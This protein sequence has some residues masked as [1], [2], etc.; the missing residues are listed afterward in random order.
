MKIV[1]TG[2][3]TGGHFYPIIA[4]TE[5]IREICKQKKFIEPTLYFLAPDPYNEKILFDNKII[6]KRV[7]A[8]KLR[9]Y[10]SI[11]NFFDFFVT[12]F[13]LIKA[14]WTMFWIYPDVVFSKGGH[15]SVPIVW[16]ANVLGIPI[17]V[18]ESDSAPG[19]ANAWAGKKALKIAVS[20]PEAM[21][22][23]SKEKVAWT[24]NPIRKNLKIA[25][26]DGAKEYLNLEPGI[27]TILILGGSQGA[28]VINNAILDSLP[29]LIKEYQIIHQVGKNSFEE[30]NSMTKIMFENS[31][32]GY[33]Y[34][35][36]AYLDDLA[37]KM[38]AGAADL[39]ISRAGSTI[40]EISNWAKPS[41]L[42]P[43]TESNNDHQRK[44]A[45]LYARTG[46][47]TVIEEGNLS[48][49][50]IITEIKRIL[51]NKEIKDS[52]VEAARSFAKP[53]AALTIAKELL[54]L[55]LSH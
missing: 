4:I 5:Q 16:A 22:Y 8:G 30:I 13:G 17:I 32:F 9:I 41:I 46:A 44:N 54:E 12:G 3:V 33:R 53:E 24:G 52:M 37:M 27:P 48:D 34:K 55:G 36:F 20:Y 40:F 7:P 6:Y 50:I 18:H 23:F 19:R 11:L 2:G 49:S 47:A 1:F 26:N 29:E 35:P 51:D 38:S 31:Q 39:I 28:Q 25:V 43:I 21:K 45:Y 15:G 14:L 10:F 42:I